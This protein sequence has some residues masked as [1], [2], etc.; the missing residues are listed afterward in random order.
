MSVRAQSHAGTTF[1]DGSVQYTMSSMFVPDPVMS[2]SIQPK[3]KTQQAAFSKA[4]NRFQREDPT[5]RVH[6]D[7]QSKETIISGMGELHLE[8]YS[9]R[10]RREYG[11]D[12]IVGKPKVSFRETCTRRANFSYLHKKQS[13]GAGQFG[14]VDGYLEPLPADHPEK[15]RAHPPSSSRGNVCAYTLLSISF[16]ARVLADCDRE[17]A[18]RQQH[19][20]RVRPRDREGLPRG[21]RGGPAARPPRAGCAHRLQRRRQPR[22]RL[23]RAGVPRCC[24]GRFCAG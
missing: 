15:V 14:R 22:R 12:T 19:S 7:T 11:V 13:G 5:F 4:L 2:L 1:T 16:C 17:P 21:V 6:F 9:E 18:R 24:K 10:M 8:I 23:Q 20:A 3:D